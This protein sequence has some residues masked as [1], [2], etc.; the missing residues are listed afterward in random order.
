MTEPITDALAQHARRGEYGD[1]PVHERRAGGRQP[2]REAV[3]GEPE[4]LTPR[5]GGTHH[6]HNRGDAVALSVH[7]F[8]D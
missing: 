2:E 3:V 4:V 5:D 1:R 7:V 8:G 6:I